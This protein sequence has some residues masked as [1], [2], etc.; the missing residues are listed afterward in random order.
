MTRYIHCQLK[1]SNEGETMPPLVPD[2]SHKLVTIIGGSGFVGRHV[3]RALAK[4]GYRIRLAVRRPDLAGH[5]Q[6]LGRVG[7]IVPVQANVRYPE[8]LEAACASAYAVINLPGLLYNASPQT[9]EAVHV[10]GAEAAGRAAAR[11]GARV[12]IQMSALGADPD[13]PSQYARTKAQGEDRARSAFPGS[14]VLRPSIIFG[15]EDGFFN[16]FA[17]MARFSP[18]LPLIG[19][20]RT[21]F[22]PVFVGDV[23]EAIALL[24]ERGVADGR[25][26]EFGG[27]EIYTFK[28]LM[29]FTLRTVMRRRLLLPLP[30]A[31]ANAAA[32]LLQLL[33]KP[34]LTIDQVQLLRRDNVVSDEAENQGR[35]L[36]G[37][38]VAARDIEA[39]VP[40]YLYRYRR[41][42]QFTEVEHRLA[43]HTVRQK[44]DR[45]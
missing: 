37:L 27:P 44:S 22:Q 9:F 2:N 10:F 16:R 34:L 19:G 6:P 23:A 41:A 33:P 28:E 39:I 42:G 24:V 38:G 1:R 20:G 25:T 30:F 7:Q 29:R 17:A 3:V 35:T 11:C 31:I 4:Q 32:A 21:R 14:I 12:F 15:P 26:H 40:A 5:I 8:S 36:R 13:S 18:V 45:H 43:D